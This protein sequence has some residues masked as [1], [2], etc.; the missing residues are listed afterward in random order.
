MGVPRIIMGDFNEILKPNERR[1]AVGSTQGM[2]ELQ[3]LLLDLE[4]VDMDIGQ[5]FTWFRKN[6]ASRIDRFWIDKELLLKIPNSKVQCKGR[7]F[8]N[9][10]PLIFTTAQVQW[11]PFPFRTLD[12]WLDEPSF[13][14]TFSLEW[15]QLSGLPL[16]KKL[17]LIKGPLKVWNMKVFGHIDTKIISFQTALKEL[18]DKAQGSSLEESDICRMEALRSQLWLWMA[19]KERYWRQLSRC[20]IIKEGDRNTKFFHLKANMRKQKNMIENKR[21]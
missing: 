2:R 20:K 16:Q 21:I 7:V 6:A 8:S 17:K 3:N 4:L 11:G 18:E 12:C 15:V 13:Q 1:G 9:H 14:K 10:H 19:R 5:N